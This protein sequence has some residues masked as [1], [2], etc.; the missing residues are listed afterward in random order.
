M[1]TKVIPKP[2]KN[3]HCIK[4]TIYSVGVDARPGPKQRI[5]NIHGPD[6]EVIETV[7][8]LNEFL[9]MSDFNQSQFAQRFAGYV[10]RRGFDNDVVLAAINDGYIIALDRLASNRVIQELTF[11][12]A[13][14]QKHDI[15]VP[16]VLLFGPGG[17]AYY[18]F[19]DYLVQEKAHGMH[20]N[21]RQ[22]QP[23]FTDETKQ[24]W[25]DAGKT[26]NWPMLVNEHGEKIP[27]QP[28]TI[29]GKLP[30]TGV[31]DK[32][33]QLWRCNQTLRYY[34]GTNR[35]PGDMPYQIIE[36]M[37]DVV[38]VSDSNLD[39]KDKYR[40]DQIVLQANRDGIESFYAVYNQM[41]SGNRDRLKY[42]WDKAR[43]ILHDY[44]MRMWEV[45]NKTWLLEGKRSPAKGVVYKPKKQASKR[46]YPHRKVPGTIY[47]N[48]GRYYWVVAG[49]MPPKPLIDPKTKPKVPGTIFKDG[50]RYYWF[51]PR[52]LKRQRLVPKGEKFSAKDRA[53]AEKVVIEKWKQIQQK[54]P[55]LAAKIIEHTRSQGLATKDKALA[56]KI[57]LKMWKDI[58]KND[59]E[60]AGKILTD[61]R[62]KP[63]DH[64]H[65][66]IV[67]NG[68]HKFIGSFKTRDKA[69]QAYIKEFEK[70]FGYPPGYNVQCM[71]KID[72]VWP[73]WEEQR[74]RL[75]LMDEHPKI[76]IIGP[77]DEAASSLQSVIKK[78]QKIDWLVK[79]VIV[80]LDD[81]SPLATEDIA[82]ISKGIRWY[83]QTKDQGKSPIV[84]GS[85][86]VD[87]DTGRIKL[88]VFRP[89]F[90]NSD[91]LLEEIYHTVFE[92]IEYKSP[93]IFGSIEKWYHRQLR[94]GSDPTLGI[95]E[96]FAEAM[97]KQ[98]SGIP[99]TIPS[100][101][102]KYA[103]NIFSRKANVPAHVIAQITDLISKI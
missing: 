43:R 14:A 101:I 82:V 50:S 3:Q 86:S 44:S 56:E 24:A 10:R 83:R 57:R 19:V 79:N 48:N 8:Q 49:K 55:S 46:K 52:W 23:S 71:P 75:S 1:Q 102:T 89:G 31:I 36:D 20:R 74:V 40:Y 98:E 91:V 84:E 47:L 11:A 35:L 62:P 70:V 18:A 69:E 13:Y 90:N 2:L 12:K 15:T 33:R 37:V 72:K 5:T 28:S 93:K 68:K 30:E 100:S 97:V 96:A 21:G 76:P 67:V 41:F 65:T 88:T 17:S 38:I 87:K 42:F 25:R 34:S 94:E 99:S 59:P 39:K 7:D 73:T 51:I 66:Q 6:S 77:M 80:M 4:N 26:A 58:Q 81:N 27:Y 63:Q 60:M 61:Y 53:T 103:Q 54:K 22:P 85:A 29:Q 32:L 64:W 45:Q 9:N 95:H 92:V 78:M 16:Q